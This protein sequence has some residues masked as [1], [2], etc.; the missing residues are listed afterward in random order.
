MAIP[1]LFS[2]AS[3]AIVIT[4]GAGH[5]GRALCELIRDCGANVLCLS[6]RGVDFQD[7]SGPGKIVSGICDV[8]DEPAFVAAVEAFAEAHGGVDAL[9]NN[10]ARAPRGIDLEMPKEEVSA[11]FAD[12]FTHYFTCSRAM[13]PMF[14]DGKGSIVNNSSIWGMVAPDPRTYLDLKNE[15]SLVLGPAKAAIL[16][17]TKYMAVVLAPD[18]VRVN[19]V[20]PGW[21]PQRRGPDNPQYMHQITSRI[22]MGRIGH[23]RELAG[24]VAFL[25]SDAAAYITG[26]AIVVDGGYTLW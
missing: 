8:T 4:G 5:L 14:R 11:V 13:L 3:R 7:N 15:P 19:A 6:S 26:Q 9:V 18:G 22:P 17:L 2:L 21:F 10:A 1:P 23:P 25:L 20:V 16:N 12:V 24:V